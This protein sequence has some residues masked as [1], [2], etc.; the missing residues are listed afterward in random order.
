MIAL[1]S[2]LQKLCGYLGNNQL[3]YPPYITQVVA[4][5]D[6]RIEAT[7]QTVYFY[8]NQP[9]ISARMK[10]P[11]SDLS[12]RGV[13]NDEATPVFSGDCFALLAMIAPRLFRSYGRTSLAMTGEL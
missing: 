12:L 7:P 10:S 9:L 13:R 1:S 2:F 8:Q 5:C 6:Q 3:L 4:I 11:A